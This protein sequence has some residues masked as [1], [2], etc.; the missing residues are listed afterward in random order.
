MLEI[1]L[2]FFFFFYICPLFIMVDV[3]FGIL[4]K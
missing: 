4:L 3:Q 1:N 2:I